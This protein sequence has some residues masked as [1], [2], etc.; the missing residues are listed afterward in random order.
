MVRIIFER[1]NKE[2][3]RYESGLVFVFPVDCTKISLVTCIDFKQN[4]GEK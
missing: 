2:G 3:I 4:T 1:V